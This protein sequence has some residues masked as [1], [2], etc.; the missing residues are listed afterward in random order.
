MIDAARILA[1]GLC[2]A[3]VVFLGAMIFAL[4]DEVESL[5]AELREDKG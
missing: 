3:W 5:R 2:A 4:N 1:L